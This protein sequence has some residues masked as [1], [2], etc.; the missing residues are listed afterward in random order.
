LPVIIG[1][2]LFTIMT[3]WRR[4]RDL[5]AEQIAGTTSDLETFIGRITNEHIPRVPGDAVI[6]T[7]R[8]EQTPPALQQLVRHTGVLH[9]RVILVTV[10]I[11]PVPKVSLEERIDLKSVEQGIYRLVLRYGFMQS[12]N[13]PSDLAECAELGLEVDLNQVHYFIGQV[14]LLAGR[15]KQ[16]MVRWRDSLFAL[17]ARN[18]QDATAYYH[19]PVAQAMTVG[20]HVGI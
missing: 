4:G 19:I 18:T 15:K 8:L 20:L 10:V 16:G 11:E 3:T 17:M 13:I 5:L 6:F 7:G 1:L 2:A 9:E 12:P 14:D